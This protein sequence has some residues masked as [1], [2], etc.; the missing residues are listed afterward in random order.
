MPA[1]RV[2][3]AIAPDTYVEMETRLWTDPGT[4]SRPSRITPTNDR[5]H[6][7][8]RAAPGDTVRLAARL[9]GEA[10]ALDDTEC[11]FSAWA[12][13]YAGG[14]PPAKSYPVVGTSAIV[15]FLLNSVGHYLLAMRMENVFDDPDMAGGV[16]FIH[17]DVTAS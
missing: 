8:Y 13:E 12:I 16:I 14:G 11:V 17:I 15:D 3:P 4:V 7:Y 5:Q 9:P 1:F 10:T 2:T 6:R